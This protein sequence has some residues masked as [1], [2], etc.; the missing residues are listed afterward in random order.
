MSILKKL[1]LKRPENRRAM[2]LVLT[3]AILVIVTGVVIAF[4]TRATSERQ[5]ESDRAQRVQADVL[6][7]SAGNY[8]IGQFLQE[9][10]T[11]SS[12]ATVNGVPYYLPLPVIAATGTSAASM[13][14]QRMLNT[15]TGSSTLF[16]S[17]SSNY[18]NLVMQSPQP[19]GSSAV[20]TDYYTTTAASNGRYI[21]PGRW[22]MPQLAAVSATSGFATVATVSGATVSGTPGILPNW[23]YVTASNIGGSVQQNGTNTIGRFAYNVYNIGG[24]FNANVA[25]YP[26]SFLASSTSSTGPLQASV[27]AADLTQLPPISGTVQLTST[28][29]DALVAFR[30]GSSAQVSGTN[31]PYVMA[32]AAAGGFLSTTATG[33][34][35][36]S[37]NTYNLNL[38]SSRQDLLRYAALYNPGIQSILPFLTTFS[39]SLNAPS[40]M[41]ADSPT[42]ATTGLSGSSTGALVPSEPGVP[43]TPA[44]QD[45]IAVRYSGN[46]PATFTHYDDYGNAT[47]YT[48]NPGDP[49]IQRRFS[50]AKL[51]WI[52]HIGPGTV[53]GTTPISA[54]AIQ[55]CF[56]LQWDKNAVMGVSGS[57]TFISPRWEY[58]ALSTGTSPGR[59]M[60]LDEVAALTGAAARE[61]NFFELLKAGILWGSL[62]RD[63][64]PEHGGL[65]ANYISGQNDVQI[66]ED[67]YYLPVTG[68]SQQTNEAVIGYGFGAPGTSGTL[69][70]GGA[71]G[72]TDAGGW[73]TFRDMQILQIGVN[74]I[75]QT[76]SGNCPNAIYSGTGT[77]TIISTVG[78]QDPTVLAQLQTLQTVYGTKDLPYLNGMYTINSYV[79]PQK[80]LASWL[81][82]SVWD[83]MAPTANTGPDT[84]TKL[85]LN[86]Y[87]DA[88]FVWN[89]WFDC[90]TG[91]ATSS[92][93]YGPITILTT[94]GSTQYPGTIY[95]PTTLNPSG[96]PGGA[97]F[98]GTAGID[99]I[100]NGS[101]APGAWGNP[102]WGY[103]YHQ[104]S[105]GVQSP[106]QWPP[107]YTPFNGAGTAAGSSRT[108][109]IVPFPYAIVNS[110]GNN[111][112]PGAR[113]QPVM[114]DTVNAPG[115][116]AL[117]VYNGNG[118]NS[119]AAG[120]GGVAGA[121]AYTPNYNL[122]SPDQLPTNPD[123]GY[124]VGV[125]I[126]GDTNET[127]PIVF[128]DPHFKSSVGAIG[129]TYV[130]SVYLV[131]GSAPPDPTKTAPLYSGTIIGFR[132]TG[133][134]NGGGI[135]GGGQAYSPDA[136]N[137]TVTFTLEYQDP[138]DQTWRPYCHFAKTSITGGGMLSSN[139][140]NLTTFAAPC[141]TGTTG[142][143]REIHVDPRTDRF[144]GS[145]ANFKFVG[146][147]NT[148]W[149]INQSLMPNSP[150]LGSYYTTCYWPASALSGSCGDPGGF[151][152]NYMN[153]WVPGSWLL[154]NN[155]LGDLF[156]NLPNPALAK[157]PPLYGGSL[158]SGTTNAFYSDPDGVVRP[159]DGALADFNTGN[160]C[161]IYTGT[162]PASYNG[163][164]G[165]IPQD[166]P[167]ISRPIVLDR[168]FRSVAEMGYAFRDEPWASLDFAPPTSAADSG[169]SALLDLFSVND[170]GPVV[171]GNVN[172][173][174]APP[175]VIQAIISGAPEDDTVGLSDTLSASE[176]LTTSSNIVSSAF[177][178]PL[179]W[180][181]GSTTIAAPYANRADIA[182]PLSYWFQQASQAANNQ[183]LEVSN[184]NCREAAIRALASS[185]DTRTWTFLIDVVAQSG[186]MPNYLPAASLHGGNFI[187]GGEKRY[188][189][190]VAI[191]RFTGK[192]VSE[193]TE[194]VEE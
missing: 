86:T 159:A 120:P 141:Y 109:G 39:P 69:T 164:D 35:S 57:Q 30:S 71:A 126:P 13:V 106:T 180:A 124:P 179:P 56:G 40:W 9:I 114:L 173:N 162:T 37:T 113:T 112:Q 183:K 135:W 44:N 79:D 80:H 189:I 84:P 17:N 89:Y 63:P 140:G 138:S 33:I 60:R 38:F 42:W 88:F 72:G 161:P 55:A 193:M 186:R 27:A 170:E 76:T 29:V 65:I 146:S 115:N 105:P 192:I 25:G 18:F 130:G 182:L 107:V 66:D 108:D 54:A 154:Y 104:A 5:V 41:A 166:H 91:P 46:T 160:G 50:L 36:S 156:Q 1:S 125:F 14:P 122:I 181:T 128:N 190:Q 137:S 143:G 31:Y 144:A 167:A 77:N 142:A 81:V 184:K 93:T 119:A 151:Y 136:Q 3:L 127:G 82:P 68:S 32:A 16:T 64:G 111:G 96:G 168:P 73:S 102:T 4:F 129:G 187:V 103:C 53:S 175:P 10:G 83:P 185:A 34:V 131:S 171:A 12:A 97:W 62:G 150:K 51:P 191:D 165:A 24:L 157:A 169:D 47:T 20:P 188:W 147:T 94:S 90:I 67:T 133:G 78:V 194:P 43:G 22:D 58:T 163:V 177:T 99:P 148:S 110:S 134:G 23:I 117:R 11:S 75:D 152:Y 174:T 15:T 70:T 139:I 95:G 100:Y 98:T 19:T 172:I 6:A 21:A 49:L 26:S 176:A 8:V 132:T 101:P 145:T 48:V 87:G 118:E 2:A 123:G 178:N 74:L 116:T 153:P 28:A 45:I 7:Q 121:P 92:S 52:T 85:R 61:P 155:V 158:I 59:I 149:D